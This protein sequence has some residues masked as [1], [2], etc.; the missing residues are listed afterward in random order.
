MQCDDKDMSNFNNIYT[1]CSFHIFLLAL[2]GP[3]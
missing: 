3:E 1:Y 2:K